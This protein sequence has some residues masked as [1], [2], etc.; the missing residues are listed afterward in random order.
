VR[1]RTVCRYSSQNS[2]VQSGFRVTVEWLSDIPSF[3]ASPP[4]GRSPCANEW[5]EEFERQHRRRDALTGEEKRK[6]ELRAR[7]AAATAGTS[8]GTSRRLPFSVCRRPVAVSVDSLA[9]SRQI[10]I[11]ARENLVELPDDEE[12]NPVN[13]KHEKQNHEFRH[14]QR[15]H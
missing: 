12:R 7:N 10:V 6:I 8:G 2:K 3:A 9:N 14:T 13:E 5:N 1:E 11:H 15:R 4:D